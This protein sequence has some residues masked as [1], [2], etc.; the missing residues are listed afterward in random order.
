MEVQENGGRKGERE[1]GR[2]GGRDKLLS[3]HHTSDKFVFNVILSFKEKQG[4]QPEQSEFLRKKSC[5]GGTRTR[6]HCL[7]GRILFCTKFV[8]KNSSELTPYCPSISLLC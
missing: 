5:T 8:H 7:L 1:E 4:N 3:L 6:T 2:E